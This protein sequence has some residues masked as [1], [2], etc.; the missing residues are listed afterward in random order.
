[1]LLHLRIHDFYRQLWQS[2]TIFRRPG[3]LEDIAALVDLDMRVAAEFLATGTRGSS[4]AA[5]SLEVEVIPA[6]AGA[7]KLS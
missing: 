7:L 1:M 4:Q 2:S 3:S 5:D 6:P